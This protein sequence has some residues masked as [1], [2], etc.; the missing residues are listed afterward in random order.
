MT[1]NERSETFFVVAGE[2]S[3]DMHGGT[4]S[5][6]IKKGTRTVGLLDTV[7]IEWLKVG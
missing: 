3:G 4:L 2:A 7:V 5:N 1:R 6:E